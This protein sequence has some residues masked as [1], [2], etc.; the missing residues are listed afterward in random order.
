M[1]SRS[2]P[3]PS[4][5][6][7]CGMLRVQEVTMRHLLRAAAMAAVCLFPCFTGALADG[8]GDNT[9]YRN[10]GWADSTPDVRRAARAR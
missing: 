3:E 7:A 5:S 1:C 2:Q 6:A 8:W 9:A 10:S 4:R